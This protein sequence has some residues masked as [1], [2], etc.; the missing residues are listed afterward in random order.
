MYFAQFYGKKSLASLPA[1]CSRSARAKRNRSKLVALP[2]RKKS[3]MIDREDIGGLREALY[4]LALA[5]GVSRPYRA[6][7]QGPDARGHRGQ[8]RSRQPVQAGVQGA[9]PAG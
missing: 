7:P 8:P 9:E 1:I 5:G 4:L 3:R 2:L 6:Q